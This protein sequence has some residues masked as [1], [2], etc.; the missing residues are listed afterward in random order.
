MSY[1]VV[2]EGK[3]DTGDI[4]IVNGSG[5]GGQAHFNGLTNVTINQG[6]DFDLTDGVTALDK[7]GNE[8][9][10]TVSPESVDKCAVGEQTFTYTAEGIEDTR[11]ITVRQISDPTISGLSE[12]TVEVNEEFDP[13]EGVSAV[14]GNGNE[15]EVTYDEP[16]Q[17]VKIVDVANYTAPNSTPT[18]QTNPWAWE[19]PFEYEAEDVLADGVP[20]TVNGIDAYNDTTIVLKF[21][22]FEV[23]LLGREDYHTFTSTVTGVNLPNEVTFGRLIIKY[24]EE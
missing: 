10:F 14:D 12:L 6:I 4:A 2:Y 23:E 19:H 1:W 16:T 21:S 17:Y 20:V 18:A 9:P 13:L 22:D 11:T 3:G 5:G 7:D 15:V 8:I 24:T